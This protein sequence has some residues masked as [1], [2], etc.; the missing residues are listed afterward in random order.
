MAMSFEKYYSG[1]EDI[2]WGKCKLAREALGLPGP[3]G[4][5]ECETE[6]CREH[7]QFMEAC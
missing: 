5:E 3:T 2:A 7:C 4:L 1:M 6:P